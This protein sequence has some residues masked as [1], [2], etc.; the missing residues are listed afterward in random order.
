MADDGGGHAGEPVRRICGWLGIAMLMAAFGV[1]FATRE[2]LSNWSGWQ[3]WAF[4]SLAVAGGSL[5]VIDWWTHFRR[6]RARRQA[7]RQAGKDRL[8]LDL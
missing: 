4:W 6:Q 2:E 7:R 3:A 5:V 8:K 1:S